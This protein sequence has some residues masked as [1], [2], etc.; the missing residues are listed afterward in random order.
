LV[1]LALR[2]RRS[3]S[4][5]ALLVAAAVALMLAAVRPASAQYLNAYKSGLEAIEAEDWER[6]E[7]AMQEAVSERTEEKLKL[8]VKLFLRPYLPHFYLGQARY[9]R[10]DCAGALAAW[11]ESERQGVATKLPDFE[12]ARRG[13][14]SC[15][16]RSRLQIAAQARQEAQQSLARSTTTAAELLE[17]SRAPQVRPHWSEGDPSPSS[18]HDRGMELLAQ[19]RELLAATSVDAL[20]I[21]RAEVLIRDADQSF[22]AGGKELDRLTEATRL[23]LVAK[24]KG[25]DA[26]VAEAKAALARTAYLA[27]YPRAVRKARADLEGLVAEADRRTGTSKAQLDA[28]AARLDSSIDALGKLTAA[29][30]SRLEKAADAYLDGRHGDVVAELA[31]AKFSE[32]R[33]RA[34]ARL[35]LAASRH[36]LYLEGGELDDELRAAAADDARASREE[37]ESLE[38]SPRFFSPRFVSFWNDSVAAEPAPSG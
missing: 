4:G 31:A 26:S 8:P 38:P 1:A 27:P 37:D 29:P 23:E 2:R 21:K 35:L 33:A 14:K 3:R 24:G 22:A 12:V 16:E 9:E 36:A 32:R 30:P 10:G 7:S 19:A 11:A 18:L 15:E 28:L 20:G 25:I 17:R 34:H 13:R 6:A 5:S